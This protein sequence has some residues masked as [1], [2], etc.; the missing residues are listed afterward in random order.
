MDYFKDSPNLKI[1][2]FLRDVCGHLLS[3][4]ESEKNALPV[5]GVGFLGLLDDG[6]EHHPLPER[7]V[8]PQRILLWRTL[9]NMRAS[10]KLALNED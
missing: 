9:T 3:I 7:N 4:G 5:C 1:V 10:P 6:L 2:P 8:V